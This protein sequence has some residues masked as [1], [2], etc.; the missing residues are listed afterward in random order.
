MEIPG[1]VLSIQVG[2]TEDEFKMRIFCVLY[3]YL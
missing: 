2:R 3:L 1:H